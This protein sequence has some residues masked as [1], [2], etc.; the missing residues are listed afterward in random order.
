MNKIKNKY[1]HNVEL[2]AKINNDRLYFRN[3]SIFSFS[4]YYE[5]YPNAL[6][7]IMAYSLAM[8]NYDF[9]SGSSEIIKHNKN[10]RQVELSNVGSLSYHLEKLIENYTLRVSLGTQT[11]KDISANNEDS[12]ARKW[13][14]FLLDTV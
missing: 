5:G 3:S 8:V 6:I 1:I 4:S 11:K 13:F 10:G 9:P 2:L 12:I 7:E 14:N